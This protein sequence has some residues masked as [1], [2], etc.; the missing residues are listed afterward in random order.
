[1]KAPPCFAD[2]ITTGLLALVVFLWSAAGAQAQFPTVP[3][4]PDPVELS[5]DRI[6]YLEQEELYVVEGHVVLTRGSRRLTADHLLLNDVTG[7]LTAEGRV[8]FFNGRQ[9]LKADKLEL[10][11]R[12]DLGIAQQGRLFLPE[13]DYHVTGRQIEQTGPDSYR[14]TGASFTTCEGDD[15][16]RLPWRFRARRARLKVGDT[17]TATHVVM[18]VKKIPVFY[19]PYIVVPQKSRQTGFLTPRISFNSLTGWKVKEAFFI[20]LTPSQD[21]TLTLDY[22]ERL[23]TGG[24]LE[25]RYRTSLTGGG[26]LTSQFFADRTTQEERL[27]TRLSHISEPTDRLQ[28]RADL[29]LVSD[30]AVFQ[31]LSELTAE[32]SQR[33]LDSNAFLAWRGD[34]QHLVARAQFL[35]D[36]TEGETRGL[37]RLPELSYSLLDQ[38]LWRGLPLSASLDAGAVHFLQ[39][40]AVL[41]NDVVIRPQGSTYR[42]DLYPRLFL[43]L[44]LGRVATLTPM[45]GYRLTSYSRGQSDEASHHRTVPVLA[46]EARTTLT[47]VGA[48]ADHEAVRHLIEPSV[49]YEYVPPRDQDALPR[50]DDLDRLPEKNLVTYQL[51]SRMLRGGHEPLSLILTQSYRLTTHTTSDV[52]AELAVRTSQWLAVGVEAF[53]SSDT[54]TVTA[55]NPDL[56]LQGRVA[57]L[58][59]TQRYRREGAIPK[60]GDIFNPL[61]LGEDVEEIEQP[62]RFLT[63]SAGLRL[64]GGVNLSGT[65]YYD[66]EASRL[67]DTKSTLVWA[68][69][70]WTLTLSYL[71]FANKDQV[72]V[73][74]TLKGLGTTGTVG[75]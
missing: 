24:E 35:Q 47:R 17:L 60:K 13:A 15:P 45:A 30:V 75:D 59:I 65:V 29:T 42:A 73:L 8:E 56:T 32:R 26:T 16:C 4:G 70:C 48:P 5:A 31:D 9:T 54:G 68:R 10:N 41:K 27:V 61:S 57:N 39:D 63:A 71:H 3:P 64:P 58:R 67:R 25:Y 46:V 51:A 37:L 43:P 38:R 7:E 33:S 50:F 22:R 14:V 49:V 23:G 6:E 12:T 72:S 20:V 21:A 1:M 40:E 2:E 18:F 11:L 19:L 28:F 34:R 53:F 52:R 62:I 44:R 74:I 36:L 66:Q 69:Q 55:L